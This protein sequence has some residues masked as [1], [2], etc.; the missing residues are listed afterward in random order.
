MTAKCTAA[1][2]K[3]SRSLTLAFLSSNMCT[4]SALQCLAAHIKDVRASSSRMLMK[5]PMF[6][7]SSA[8]CQSSFCAA[9]SKRS[10][11]PRIFST[12]SPTVRC[13]VCRFWM[14]CPLSSSKRGFAPKRITNWS[15]STEPLSAAHIN[16]VQPFSSRAST[17][18]PASMAAAA[19]SMSFSCAA[20]CK[21][22]VISP[23]ARTVAAISMCSWQWSRTVSP[24]W[25]RIRRFTPEQRNTSTMSSFP[26]RAAHMVGVRPSQSAFVKSA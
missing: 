14:A 5:A 26:C 11:A 1:Q 10:F 13:C 2:P 17:S 6:S 4:A 7:S 19:A 18:A 16:G 24:A 25:S 23:T 12:S 22:S 8:V 20:W 15:M 9:S 21:L 3:L